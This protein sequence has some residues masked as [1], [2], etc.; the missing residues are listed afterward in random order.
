VGKIKNTTKAKK[1]QLLIKNASADVVEEHEFFRYGKMVNLFFVSHQGFNSGTMTLKSFLP[2]K[3][4]LKILGLL[5]PPPS[6]ILK[7]NVK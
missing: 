1:Q 4:S 7:T 2:Y 6:Y 5:G 3:C